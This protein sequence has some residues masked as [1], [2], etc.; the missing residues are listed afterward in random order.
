[1]VTPAASGVARRHADHAGRL[2]PAVQA[3]VLSVVYPDA[4]A[5]C[6]KRVR[7][8]RRRAR[9]SRGA[10]RPP[11]GARRG[12]RRDAGGFRRGRPGR[13]R[14]GRASVRCVRRALRV[15]RGR[16]QP[17]VL[18]VAHARHRHPRLPRR[19]VARRHAS[20]LPAPLIVGPARATRARSSRARDRGGGTRDVGHASD[21]RRGRPLPPC[22]HPDPAHAI[23]RP[24]APRWWTCGLSPRRI[25]CRRCSRARRF[26]SSPSRRTTS[27][28][29]LFDGAFVSPLPV[30]QALADGFTDLVVI[31]SL[32]RWKNPP[33]YEEWI[34][35]ALAGRR[36]V[37]SRVV[38]SVADRTRRAQGRAR[39]ASQAPARDQR[40]RGGAGRA[41]R[42][43]ARATS[44]LGAAVRRR[45]PG[46]GARGGRAREAAGNAMTAG[47]YCIRRA[48]DG[49]A[50]AILEIVNRAFGAQDP[51]YVPRGA[52]WWSW[53]YERNP[54]GSRS[55]VIEDPEGKVVG[56]YG[57]QIARMR[58]AGGE[59]A[60]SQ[61]CD[62]V[63]DPLVRRGLRNPG[64]FVRLAQA[65]ASTFG[66]SGCDAVMY[67]LPIPEAYRI[68]AR[69]LDYWMLRSQPM[70]ICRDPARLPPWAWEVHALEVASF[71]HETDDAWQRI[72][73]ALWMRRPARRRLPELALPRSLGASVPHGG[74]ARRGR[75][76][77][78]RPRGLP[79][80][81][82]SRG[83]DAA[84][85]RTGS[86]TPRTTPRARA[87]CG[88]R[89]SARRRPVTPRSRSCARRRV[90]GSR[91]S[92]NGG[93]RSTG[94][95]T[96]SWRG[97]TISG[98][99]PPGS[100][101]TGTTRSRTSTSYERL[102]GQTLD[103]RGPRRDRRRIRARVREAAGR[104]R[105]EDPVGASKRIRP[106]HPA[107]WPPMPA[108]S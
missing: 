103:R 67:G 68:G 7:G 59:V 107:S 62:T 85:S 99:R 55:L 88:G 92:R 3:N 6:P 44:A 93:S 60:F 4:H 53:K 61:S 49:D 32:P 70:L 74:R 36:K 69:Y 50:R 17:D 37:S 43:G 95:R 84:S 1:M 30:Q 51:A 14:R 97:P 94:R 101:P 16:A 80:R 5:P 47:G 26:R 20:L 10:K 64:T 83:G 28:K 45:R 63:T 96:C 98:S 65:W 25:S 29:R 66:A 34:L 8:A 57:G 12:G 87:S 72:A 13:L 54:H 108:G 90:P 46:L 81:S 38:R 33:A 79:G 19:P 24:A 27:A 77:A 21:R 42:D 48:V 100:A 2:K 82:I 23:G 102:P 18:G 41:P 9:A 71:D 11:R 39:N 56:H 22:A 105:R 40:D 89:P 52:E 86:S 91:G 15:Q 78:S 31:L 58:T 75:R 35:R 73:P 76:T 104:R 106:G